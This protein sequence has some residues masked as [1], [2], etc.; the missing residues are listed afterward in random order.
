[1]S[2]ADELKQRGNQQFSSGQFAEAIVTFTEAIALA[3]ENHVLYSNR[4]A[5][6]ASS[7]QYNEALQDA[8][9]TIGLKPDWPKGYSRKGAALFG[10]QRYEDAREGFKEGLKYDANNAQLQKGMDDVE[11]AILKRDHPEAVGGI[12][13]IFS[14][15]L[16]GKIAKNP[17]LAPYLA[18]PDFMAKVHAIQK[19]PSALNQHLQDPRMMNLMMGLM[20]VNMSSGFGADQAASEATPSVPM[21]QDQPKAPEPEPEPEPEPVELS[22]E[23]KQ[24]QE[25]LVEKDLG[26][27]CY[28][29]RD[30]EQALVHYAKAWELDSTNITILTNKAAVYFEQAE[31]DQ[32]IA[33]C[34]EAIDVGRE[35]R[36]DYKIIAKAFARIGN[37]YSRKD[38][39]PNA[40]KYYQ[41]SLTEHRT[42]DTLKRLKELEKKQQEEEKLA[43]HNPELADK[44]REAGNA[45]FKNE[46]FAE[47]VKRY[48]EAIRR[49]ESD[50]R[51]Y[52]NRAAC[53]IKLMAFPEAHKDCEKC[54][55]LDPTFVKAYIRRANIEFF[56]KEYTK[57]LETCQEAKSHDKEHKHTW[58]IDQ[59]INKCYQALNAAQSD[60]P[61][62]REEAMRRAASDPEIQQIV[63]DPVMQQIL[64]QMQTN[65]QA[66]R[67]HMRNPAVASKINKLINAGVI[68]VG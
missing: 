8:E 15:D 67:E 63:S 28:K 16:V 55:E 7:K 32:C 44:E 58:E 48:T 11:R 52:S 30:F 53:Y 54:L 2:T 43:Y 24:K 5:A 61:E 50:P 60:T 3:P 12:Q 19:D 29:K 59:L 39:V 20:G 62:A 25:S 31:Y 45:L 23:E 26:N 42:S 57:C 14:G 9:K 36:V 4:S 68:R 35:H 37:A 21:D 1:M 13:D 17:Q 34:E 22:E 51:S 40:I 47:A 18:Q 41:K 49:N 6:Y 10:L 65:P 33:T 56:K 64:Q 27:Q 46:N 38:D 66:V